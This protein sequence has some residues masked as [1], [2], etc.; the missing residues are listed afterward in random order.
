[1]VSTSNAAILSATIQTREFSKNSAPR[2]T[3][4]KPCEKNNILVHSDLKTTIASA[5][6]RLFTNQNVLAVC[7]VAIFGY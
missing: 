5:M 2:Y 6:F 3:A 4:Q 7:T 1:M